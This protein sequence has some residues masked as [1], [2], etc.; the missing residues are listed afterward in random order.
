VQ[1]VFLEGT[2]PGP[3]TLFMLTVTAPGNRRHR[4]LT[5]DGRPWCECTSA[6]GVDLAAWNG[7]QGTRW[8]RFMQALR[9]SGLLGPDLQ[10]G[11]AVE[12]QQRGALHEH[13]LVRSSVVVR[14]TPQLLAEVRSLAIEHGYGHEV[15]IDR[16]AVSEDGRA[17]LA[18]WY[19]AKYVSKAT[20]DR[21][22]IPWERRPVL[23]DVET[24]EVVK[25]SPATYKTWTASRGWGCSMKQVRAAQRLWARS[26]VD[27]V[28]LAAA[29]SPPTVERPQVV[30]R[31]GAPP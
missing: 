11:R 1:V 24:G 9:R 29:G 7:E 2:R 17:R 6:A 8:N 4:D 22:S 26:G 28:S 31:S 13:V 21:A 10:Y 23:V 30:A 19:A 3:G 12:T 5:A 15:R 16:P 25:E 14:S 18:A 20:D 27:I